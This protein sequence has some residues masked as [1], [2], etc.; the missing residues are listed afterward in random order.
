MELYILIRLPIAAAASALFGYICVRHT[1][2]FSSA[3]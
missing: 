1:P 2:N 3:S